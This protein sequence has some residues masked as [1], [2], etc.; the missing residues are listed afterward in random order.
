M[1]RCA[2]VRMD[3][4]SPEKLETIF[5]ALEPETR[6]SPTNRSSISMEKKERCL[7]LRID[8][9]DTGALRAAANSYLRW[10]DSITTILNFLD[11][12]RRKLG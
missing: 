6:C 10:V 5:N 11:D 12:E 8:A 4:P 2:I 3:L 9:K 7:I 1:K